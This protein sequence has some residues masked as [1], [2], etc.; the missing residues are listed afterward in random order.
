M[1]GRPPSRQQAVP[2]RDERPD[3][4][5][6]PRSTGHAGKRMNQPE[7]ALKKES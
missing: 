1:S 3:G 2:R 6:P 4:A 5:A 7:R